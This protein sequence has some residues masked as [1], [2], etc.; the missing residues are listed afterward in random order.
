MPLKN[1]IEASTLKFW[2][3]SQ[4]YIYVSNVHNFNLKA[5]PFIHFTD[6]WTNL[7]TLNSSNNLNFVYDA[8]MGHIVGEM[9]KTYPIISYNINCEKISEKFQ[10]SQNKILYHKQK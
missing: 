3:T 2:I 9:P 5:C 8:P 4:S 1:T 7:H 10:K 6:S